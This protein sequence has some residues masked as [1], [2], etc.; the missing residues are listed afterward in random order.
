MN[1]HCGLIVNSSRGIIYAG[2]GP[3]YAEAARAKAQELQQK[4]AKALEERKLL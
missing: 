3:D 1:R 2:S 4:M